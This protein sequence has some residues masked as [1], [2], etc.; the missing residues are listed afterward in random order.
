MVDESSLASTKQMRDFLQKIGSEDRVLLIGDTRQHQGV[1]A[2]KPFEQMV[3]VGMRASELDQI[4]RQKSNPELLRV[5]EH[6]SH[7]EVAEG[8]GLLEQQGRV[9]EI[10]DPQKRIAAIA[11][12]YA[13]NPD[14]TIVVSPD[15]ASRRAINQAIRAELQTLGV[16]EAYD[17]AFR[18][19]ATRSDITGADRT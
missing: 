8:I 10:A 2:G 16:V 7:G 11:R 13:A 18:V 6:L 3:Q 4:V 19:L 15:N 1:E 14:N 17:H 12:N 9:T 5:V